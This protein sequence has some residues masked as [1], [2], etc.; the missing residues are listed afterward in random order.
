MTNEKYEIKTTPE[1]YTF[2]IKGP[3][4]DMTIEIIGPGDLQLAKEAMK[5]V[6]FHEQLKHP[7]FVIKENEEK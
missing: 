5:K 3:G 2:S 1:N 4:I 7:A 6:E